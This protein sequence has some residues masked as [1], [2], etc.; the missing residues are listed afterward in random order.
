M[1]LP[2]ISLLALKIFI[3]A[4]DHGKP[5]LR[6]LKP[7]PVFVFIGSTFSITVDKLKRSTTTMK[8]KFIM[9]NVSLEDIGYIGV[10]VQGADRIANCKYEKEIAPQEE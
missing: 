6:T 4:E 8:L 10:V 3:S 1:P 7:V 9:A 5:S 2:T